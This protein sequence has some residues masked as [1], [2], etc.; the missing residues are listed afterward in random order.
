MTT[1]PL[2]L[3]TNSEQKAFRRCGREHHLAYELGYRSTH[4]AE[5]LRFGSLFHLGLET[6]WRSGWDLQAALVAIG[7]NEDT[8]D[9]Y[10]LAR[11]VILLT[12]YSVRWAD[13]FADLEVLHV[14]HTFTA[15]LLNPSTGAASRTFE[16]GGKLDV[17]VRQRS[18]GLVFI[19][20]HK[21]SSD[22]IAAGSQY[23]QLLQLDT[24]VSTYYAGVRS[25]G[26]DVAGCIY[27]VIGK[28]GQRPK[29]VPVLDLD[30][31]PIVHDADGFR[32]RTKDNKRWRITADASQGYALVT[33]PE[34]PEEFAARLADVLMA[35]P[36]RYFQRGTVVR[37][38]S[39]E[40]DAAF[41]AW[42]TARNIRDAALANRHPR[43]PD[44]CRRFGRVCSYFPVCTGQASLDD[45]SL[46][47]R[48]DDVHAELST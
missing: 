7:A 38:E 45:P 31:T 16:L 21:T 28:P 2:R 40:R 8:S 42:Q 43:N 22:D 35:D 5:A 34:T 10:D 37:L 18:T 46:F 23:W 41:D 25:M 39:E 48:V 14:E 29:S 13:E 27:D 24:Q 20:E 4:E 12:G 15:P 32:V 19:V 17:L 26:Y 9:P 1:T 47:V 30:G 44:A 3:L 36:D 11:A 33:R 6:L